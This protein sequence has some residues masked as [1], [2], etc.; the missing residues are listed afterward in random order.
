MVAANNINLKIKNG[1]SLSYV[2]DKQ[3]DKELGTD[4]QLGIN[5]WTSVFNLVKQNQVETNRSQFG[6]KD[7]DVKNGKHFVVQAGEEY[8]IKQSVWTKIVDIA[9]K[10]M[11]I[12]DKEPE[13]TVVASEEQAVSTEEEKT[14]VQSNEEI[15]RSILTDANLDCDNSDFINILSKYENMVSY[16]QNNS[17]EVNDEK[18]KERIVNYAKGLQYHKAEAGFALNNSGEPI[19]VEGVKEA[20]ENNDM[21]A[22]KAA[23]HQKAKEYIELYDNNND[24]KINPDE[25][26]AME[27]KELGRALTQE[28]KSIVQEEVVNRLAILNQDKDSALDENEISAYMWAMSKIN[29]GRSGKTAQDITFEE[30]NV[31]QTSMGI[32][33]GTKLTEDQWNVILSAVPLIT[34]TGKSI[35]VL[36]TEDLSNLS[37]TEEDKKTLE[38]ALTLLEENG[39]TQEMIDNYAKFDT[40]L[41]IG[42][43]NLKK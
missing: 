42:Y 32:L 30:W 9:K 4:V 18:I 43:E 14:S 28:E 35:D 31:S 40:A 3:L 22:F 11:G 8:Q 29:D 37:L 12:T 19:I 5:D 33:S 2:I 13:E 1:E 15:V 38:T 24:G 21:E 41:K 25:L 10:K 34:N 39:F 7:T 16:A 6:D 23:F 26:I 36:Y 20:V 17:A 27:E